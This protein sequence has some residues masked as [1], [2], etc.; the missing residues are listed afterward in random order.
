MFQRIKR[1]VFIRINRALN[2]HVLKTQNVVHGAGLQI[3]GRIKVVNWGKIRIGERFRV[4][5]G[6]NYNIIGGDTRTNLI[7][8]KNGELEIHNNVGISN[9]TIVC[10]RRVCI[11][12]DVRIGG[13]CKIYDT[14]FHSIHYADRMCAE[15][16]GIKTEEVLIKRGAFIGAHSIILK[17]VQIG[18]KSVVGAGSVV[19]RSI[20]DNEI[21]GGN[22]AVFIRKLEESKP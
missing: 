10:A 19:R 21:W 1:E 18:E 3:N 11:E 13:G 6:R 16:P 12:D 5:S 9:S 7:V 8:K 2:A 15:D 20:P 4:N 14:D 22:P 17:G